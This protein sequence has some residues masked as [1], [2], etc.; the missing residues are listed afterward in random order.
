MSDQQG[1]ERFTKALRIA[2]DGVTLD[3]L[4]ISNKRRKEVEYRMVIVQLVKIKSTL[5]L[6]F[7]YRYETKDITK[8]FSIQEGLQLIDELLKDKFLQAELVTKEKTYYLSIFKSG[9][10]K[11]REKVNQKKAKIETSHDKKKDRMIES[12]NNIYLQKLGVTT[13]TG[14]VKKRMHDKFKQINKYIEIIHDILKK[15]KLPSNPT[16]V[17]MGSGKGYLTFALADYFQNIRKEEVNVVGVEIREELVSF[18]NDLVKQTDLKNLSFKGGSIQE[19]EFEK[20]DFLIALHACDTATDDALHLGLQHHSQLIIA[21]PCCHKQVRKQ[22]ETSG[23]L[24]QITKHG[25]LKERQAE[26]LTDT[27]RAEILE[28]YGYHTRVFEF[29][30]TEHTP[31]NVLIVASM[32]EAVTNPDPEKIQNIQTL[33]KSYGIKHQ[34]LEKLMGII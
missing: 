30:S 9:N 18:C 26:I 32:D 8:N 20:I 11:C 19:A 10:T 22:M 6:Q 17:D 14:G 5:H 29:I 3:V 27:I 7:V 33:K 24:E 1:F 12:N 25:I 16:I 2:T 34:H 23:T 21:A 4:R 31:K 28:S 13:E 15:T